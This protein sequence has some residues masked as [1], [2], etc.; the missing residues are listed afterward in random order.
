MAATS[1]T[2]WRTEFVLKRAR[3]RLEKLWYYFRQGGIR[4][5]WRKL[6]WKS[7]PDDF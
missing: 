5:V 7:E 3:I 1:S 4:L 2:C 6:G